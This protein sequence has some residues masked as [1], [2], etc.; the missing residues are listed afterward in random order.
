MK[1]FQQYSIPKMIESNLEKKPKKGSL[2][3]D[4]P[5]FS[6]QRL[7][8]VDEALQKWKTRG[9]GAKQASN[10]VDVVV[11]QVKN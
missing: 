5:L 8:L 2:F 11:H 1:T 7:N 9:K 10:Q 4:V 3:N 6:K